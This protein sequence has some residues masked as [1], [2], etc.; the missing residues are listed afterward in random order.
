MTTASDN[1]T[2]VAGQG[3]APRAGAATSWQ[4]DPSGSTVTISHKTIWGLVTVRGEFTDLSGSA[5]ILPDGSAHGRLEIGAESLSTKHGKRD[6]HLRSADFFNVAE[7][8]QIVVDVTEATRR[9]GDS[10]A[11]NGTMSVAGQTKPLTLTAT[12]TEATDEAITLKADTQIDRADFGMS[13]NQL[14]M[15]KGTAQVSVVARFVRPA[16]A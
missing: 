1:D 4:L 10:V 15:I 8:P 16:T 2:G 5:E 13:W 6:E 7:H 14:G 12:V 9:D 3:A 11:A